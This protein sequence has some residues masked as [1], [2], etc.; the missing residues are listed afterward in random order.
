MRSLSNSLLA[1]TF[2]FALGTFGCA[3]APK[4]PFDTLKDS[5]AT[6]FR[7][8]NYE[9]PA[10]PPG[11]A[12]PAPGAIP[13]LPPEIQQWIQQGAQALPQLIPPGLI[14]PGLIPGAPAAA[15]PPQQDV[16]RFHNFRILAQTPIMDPKLKEKLADLLGDEDSFDNSNARCAP[17]VLYAEMGLSW[18]AGPGAS[19]DLLISFSCSQVVSRSFA[20]PHPATGMKPNTVKELSEVVQKLWPQGA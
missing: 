9:P 8:Q 2:A 10:P 20:W 1:K 18:S 17:G 13:G 19:N 3:G 4:A 5:N 16:P 11:A 15:P 14:P 6:A 12:A 7:L